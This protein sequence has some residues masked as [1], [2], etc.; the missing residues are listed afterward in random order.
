MDISLNLCRIGN[1][2]ADGH[3]QKKDLIALFLK[4]T[5][6]C[7]QTFKHD[8]LTSDGK[9]MFFYFKKEFDKL[10]LEEITEKNNE[11][12]AERALTWANILQHRAELA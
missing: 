9:L 11:W 7:V 1:W 5:E 3:E 10:R 4:K 6:E 12:W 2:A 8:G